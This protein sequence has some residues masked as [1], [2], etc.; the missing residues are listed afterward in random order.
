MDIGCCT[1][2]NYEVKIK[3]KT[4]PFIAQIDYNLCGNI[5]GK[6]KGIT[7]RFNDRITGIKAIDADAMKSISIL[8]E[9]GSSKSTGTDVNSG[10]AIVGLR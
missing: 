9:M 7:M 4:L 5:L 2:K 1:T 8:L 3:S 10:G 6:E